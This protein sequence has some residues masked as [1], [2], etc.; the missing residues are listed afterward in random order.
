MMHAVT[1]ACIAL[2]GLG[3]IC[4]EQRLSGP[5]SLCWAMLISGLL[6]TYDSHSHW[7]LTYYHLS[8]NKYTKLLRKLAGRFTTF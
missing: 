1:T 3:T 7:C 2:T 8:G 6:A 4:I 5:K